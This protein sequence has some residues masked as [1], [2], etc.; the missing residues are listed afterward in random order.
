MILKT[1][2]LGEYKKKNLIIETWG[3]VILRDY[4]DEKIY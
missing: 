1:T 2:R 3:S 4:K